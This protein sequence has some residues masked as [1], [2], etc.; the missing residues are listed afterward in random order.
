MP[1]KKQVVQKQK[2]QKV[3]RPGEMAADMRHV[4]PKGV[5]RLFSNYPL[6]AAIGVVGIGAGLL[7]AVL[8]SGNRAPSSSGDSG[9]RGQGV[10]RTTPEAGATTESGAASTIKQYSAPPAMTID[11]AKTYTAT[12]KTEKGDVT[13]QLDASAAPEAVNN[14]V[15][16]ARDGFYDGSTFYRVVADTSGTLHFAQAGDPTGTGSGGS[17]TNIPFE[18]ND[19]KH[20]K[21]VLAMARS[22]SKDSADSQFYITLDA[23]PSLD[24]EYVV[25]GRVTEGMD[26][27]E[28]IAQGDKMTKVTVGP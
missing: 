26:V 3:Y 21:G 11:A 12:I 5:F 22:Q 1:R 23:Q 9:V 15:F 8:L 13:V 4:K 20:E 6:F 16:L 25:F 18:E 24:G 28:R 7:F 2:R 19:L 27:V 14:F 17:G 10:I